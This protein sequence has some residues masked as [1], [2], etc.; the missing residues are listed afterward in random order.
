MCKAIAEKVIENYVLCRGKA[1]KTGETGAEEDR[2][3]N[4]KAEEGTGKE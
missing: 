2:M 1:L 4:G 3:G